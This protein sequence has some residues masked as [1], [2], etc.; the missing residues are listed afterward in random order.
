DFLTK[1]CADRSPTPPATLGFSACSDA[2]PVAGVRESIYIVGDS[3][4]SMF[5]ILSEPEAEVL[6]PEWCALLL[7]AGGTRHIG[8]NRNWVEAARRWAVRGI[9]SLR[10]DLLGI[11]ESDGDPV[12]NNPALYQDDLVEQVERAMDSL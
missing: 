4:A 7:N 1:G 8:P 5:G 11:G 12:L 2:T 9:P 3:P 6:E 10:L